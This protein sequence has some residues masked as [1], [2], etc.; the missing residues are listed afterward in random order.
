MQNKSQIL[1]KNDEK[2]RF[3]AIFANFWPFLINFAPYKG[4]LLVKMNVSESFSVVAHNL[5]I[6]SRFYCQKMPI[7]GDFSAFFGHFFTVLM[8]FLTIYC[9]CANKKWSASN[10]W[11]FKHDLLFTILHTCKEIFNFFN[12]IKENFSSSWFWKNSKSRCIGNI[13]KSG[14]IYIFL[15]L[16]L[17][18]RKIFPPLTPRPPSPVRIIILDVFWF[19]VTDGWL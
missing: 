14:E 2:R 18:G 12:G 17:Y 15:G 7:F 19:N 6:F 10:I 8:P 1:T 9:A 5:I 13:S 4:L 3:F 16:V 11:S